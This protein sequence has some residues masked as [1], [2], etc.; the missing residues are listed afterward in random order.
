[1]EGALNLYDA[2][3]CRGRVHKFAS[4]EGPMILRVGV[5]VFSHPKNGDQYP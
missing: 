1:M 3:V 2:G 4:F 5:D